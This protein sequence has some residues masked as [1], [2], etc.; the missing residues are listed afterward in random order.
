MSDSDYTLISLAVQKIS[1]T[2]EVKQQ[3][4]NDKTGL[5]NKISQHNGLF[6]GIKN[7]KNYPYEYGV[8]VNETYSKK[9][10][11]D[12]FINDNLTEYIYGGEIRLEDWEIAANK[13]NL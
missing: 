7:N 10:M 12:L 11:Y 4:M 1:T 9:R 6:I 3:I 5:F 2:N 13:Y 8:V